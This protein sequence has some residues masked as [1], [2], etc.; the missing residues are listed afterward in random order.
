MHLR[1]EGAAGR[2]CGDG[3]GFGVDGVFVVSSSEHND[4][5]KSDGGKSDGGSE[6]TG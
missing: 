1:E 6:G 2:G 4:G 5:G 3:V